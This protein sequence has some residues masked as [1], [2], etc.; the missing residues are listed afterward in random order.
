MVGRES[1]Y[2]PEEKRLV[3]TMVG[4][5]TTPKGDGVRER[6]DGLERG[7]GRGGEDAL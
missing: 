4:W 6:E 5:S 3:V 1:D 7:E 2:G